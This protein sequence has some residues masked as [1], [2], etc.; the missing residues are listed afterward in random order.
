MQQWVCFKPWCWTIEFRQK[1]SICCMI[2]LCYIYKRSTL[3]YA[4]GRKSV[5]C[6]WLV[7]T[8]K[9]SWVC[10]LLY[11]YIFQWGYN[12]V[13]GLLEVKSWIWN[14]THAHCIG[15]QYLNHWPTREV[16]W[17]VTPL[18]NP[19]EVKLL[20]HVWLFA[21]LWTGAYHALPSMGF[22]RQEY[23]N[24]LPFPYCG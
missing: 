9:K 19:S 2:L 6:I 17:H 20:S 4:N 5:V 18:D 11:T 14:W 24:G 1:T 12:K 10:H 15:K 13:Q 21:I 3:F 7:L 22:S 16:P 8:K 23:W